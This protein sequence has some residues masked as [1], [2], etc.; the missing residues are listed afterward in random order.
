MMKTKLIPCTFFCFGGSYNTRKL[1]DQ[2]PAIGKLA[3]KIIPICQTTLKRL[4]YG[5]ANMNL[6]R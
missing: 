5:W 4:G 1:L 2:L 6:A 3:R